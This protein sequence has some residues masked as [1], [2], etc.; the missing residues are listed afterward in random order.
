[1]SKRTMLVAAAIVLSATVVVPSAAMAQTIAEAESNASDVTMWLAIT[2]GFAMAIASSVCG[3]AQSRAVTSACEGMSRNPSASTAIRGSLIIGLVL[4][5]S[6]AI[7][8][9]LISIL[10]I[11]QFQR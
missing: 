11:F 2:C 8:T 9:L 1:M 6:L 4:I 3:Y 5:E 7:Y 10:L